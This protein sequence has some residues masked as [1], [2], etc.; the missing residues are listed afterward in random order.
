[1]F[2][3]PVHEDGSTLSCVADHYDM[4][5]STGVIGDDTFWL[6][7]VCAEHG[8]LAALNP[9]ERG[10]HGSCVSYRKNIGILS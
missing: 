4:H 9:G 3:R 2:W 7:P 1:M 10:K 8:T 5:T 6:A